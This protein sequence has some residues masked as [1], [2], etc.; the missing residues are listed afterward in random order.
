MTQYC[1][2]LLAASP[3][4]SPRPTPVA[5]I[6]IHGGV[7][8]LWVVLFARAFCLHGLLAWSTGIAYASYDT[9]LLVYVTLAAMPLT[10]STPVPVFSGPK[11]AIGVII[12]ARDEVAALPATLSAL[13]AQVEPSEEI[14]IAD[15]GSS[16]GTARLLIEAYG[17]DE[18]TLGSISRASRTI[19]SLRWL[20]LPHRGKANALNAAVAHIASPVFMTV[21]ADTLL[22]PGAVGAVRAAFAREPALVAAT[23]ILMPT[24]RGGRIARLFEWFQTYEYIRN[25]ISRY[26]W[27]RA[28][29]LLLVSGAFAGYRRDAVLEVG[30]FDPACLVEDYELSHRLHRHAIDR[31]LGWT[32]RVLGDAK[33]ITD[34]PAR[35]GAFLRQR[36]RWFAGFLQTQYWNRDMTGNGRYGLLGTLMLPIKAIDT[37]QPLYGLTAFGLLLYYAVTGQM[38]L[39][40]PIFGVIGAKIFIDLAFHLWSVKLFRGWTGA[41]GK[42]SIG[43][44]L[45]AA[46]AEPF[47]FQ[48]LRH[49]G[50]L[51]GWQ[52]FLARRQSWR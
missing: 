52:A 38:S 27:M 15:D 1:Q 35:L 17:L 4:L 30:S 20:K 42:A 34:A 45:L 32:V 50:A 43:M 6:A 28:D 10:R 14:L 18:P 23:G 41:A 11:P 16:D 37:L 51:W 40:G 36:R 7:L 21:D 39:I 19:P 12:A 29:S 24:C 47:S 44:A 31:Q 8:L 9:L 26:A 2:A 25:F 3:R 13:L 49:S 46:L 48:L 5:S 22:E 33:A